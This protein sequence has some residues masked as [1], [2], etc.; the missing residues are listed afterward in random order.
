MSISWRFEKPSEGKNEHFVWEVLQKILFHLHG[1][2][3]LKAIKFEAK[4]DT[5]ININAYQKE[6]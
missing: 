2:Y 4:I 3:I 5:Q 6:V 1:T